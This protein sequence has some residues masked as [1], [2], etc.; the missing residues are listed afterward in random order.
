MRLLAVQGDAT[1][2]DDDLVTLPSGPS[3][4]EAGAKGHFHA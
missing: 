3:N 2:R 4:P 1:R